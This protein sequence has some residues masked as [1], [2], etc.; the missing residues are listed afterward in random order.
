MRD[1]NGSEC[2]T[3]L[4]TLKRNVAC[5][6][7]PYT[8]S[9][10]KRMWITCY[11]SRA[12]KALNPMETFIIVLVLIV[13]LVLFGGA[14]YFFI[15]ET[16][17]E[18]ARLWLTAP[19]SVRRIIPKPTDTPG[20][21][22]ATRYSE[23]LEQPDPGQMNLALSDT[24]LRTLREEFHGE[25][26]RAVGQTRDF[27]A[28]LTR[29]EEDLSSTHHLRDELGQS[30][31]NVESRTGRKISRIQD[32]LRSARMADSPYGQ[33]RATSLANLYGQL[34]QVEAALAAVVNPMLLP[35]EPLKVPE[36]F[37]ED[38]LEWSNWGDVGER[39]FNF[40]ETF[41]QNRIVLDPELANRIEA[42]IATFRE[43]LTDTVYP[44][45]QNGARTPKQ[46]A[47]MRSGL[48]VIVGALPP[49]RREIEAAYR[50][51]SGTL[52]APDDEGDED[53]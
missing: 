20:R 49:L 18:N 41:N 3:G 45:V 27:D 30:M 46:V 5:V 48:M 15:R 23:Q 39:A 29:M 32:E 17:W 47:R 37:F 9:R 4:V 50:E 10:H 40:G 26:S 51:S 2:I 13:L 12:G 22:D 33:R 38:T 25:L 8:Q 24:V 11:T 6:P 28:R 35:G 21:F 34:A 19:R 53:A 16:G 31:Q 36:E 44:V 42:F 7:T 52:P 43:A 14:G 1:S